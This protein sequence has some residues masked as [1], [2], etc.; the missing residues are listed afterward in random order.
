MKINK[1]PS[2]FPRDARIVDPTNTTVVE[3]VFAT[4][5]DKQSASSLNTHDRNLTLLVQFLVYAQFYPRS[6]TANDQ[7]LQAQVK[8]MSS[9]GEPW[10]LIT[11]GH[12]SGFKRWLTANGHTDTS[13]N[14]VLATVKKYQA[15]ATQ[16][17]AGRQRLPLR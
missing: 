14:R 10:H 17:D 13:V 6:V 9:S 15:L 2:S 4:Y 1:Q 16:S 3:P 8:Y 11:W 5:R 12:L 7:S